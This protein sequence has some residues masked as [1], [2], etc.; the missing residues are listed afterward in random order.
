MV[1]C[2]VNSI[3]RHWAMA[4]IGSGH[5]GKVRISRIELLPLSKLVIERGLADRNILMRA[6]MLSLYHIF[7]ALCDQ[8]GK[9]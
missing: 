1:R 2:F 4:F 9:A 3:V 7:P 8:H 6:I 5:S